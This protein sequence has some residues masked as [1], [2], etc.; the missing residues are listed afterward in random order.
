[1]WHNL[2]NF[3]YFTEVSIIIVSLLLT[4]SKFVN[5]DWTWNIW[6]RLKK[7]LS[8]Q[9]VLKIKLSAL[10]IFTLRD[11]CS[12]CFESFF[13][14]ISTNLVE[15][16]KGYWIQVAESETRSNAKTLPSCLKQSRILLDFP[17]TIWL[18]KWQ[19]GNK[20]STTV[21]CW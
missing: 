19:H 20:R 6:Q 3:D 10:V 15:N 12:I 13:V 18:P 21:S 14:I 8:C 4:S 17:L 5:F 16:L 1:M 11:S 9:N 7:N 2:N